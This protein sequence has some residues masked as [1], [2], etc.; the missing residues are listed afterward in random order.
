MDYSC[1]TEMFG[2]FVF[3]VIKFIWIASDDKFPEASQPS[4]E[5]VSQDRLMFYRSDLDKEAE[6]QGKAHKIMKR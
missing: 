1:G 5:G 2:N 6:W 4:P 3:Y